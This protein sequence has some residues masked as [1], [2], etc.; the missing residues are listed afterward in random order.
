MYD[1]DYLYAWDLGGKDVSVTIE[2]VEAGTLTGQQGRKT[3][4]PV[5]YFRGAQKGLALNKTNGK[6]IAAMYGTDTAQWPGK[7]VTLYPTRTTMGGEEVDCVRIRP[8]PP[9][10]AK[11][12]RAPGEEG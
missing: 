10:P 7:A 1:S 5:V 3:R 6:T 4:K 11:R 2:R 12:D 9:K 8:T